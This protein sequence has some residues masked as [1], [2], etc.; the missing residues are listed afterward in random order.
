MFHEFGHA[1]H[2]MFADAEYPSSRGTSVARDFVEVPSQFNEHWASYPAI[3]THYAKHYKTGE[4]MPAELAA[5][6]EKPQTFNQGYALTELLG[7]GRTRHAVAH[8][9]R[10][11]APLQNPDA[12]EKAGAREDAPGSERRSA[13]LPLHLLHRTSGPTDTPPATTPISGARCSTTTPTSGS[14]TMAD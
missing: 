10:P 7:R 4:P 1:L 6:I 5:K 2:G 8:C 3:F 13:P 11:S 9:F 14:S 12:F